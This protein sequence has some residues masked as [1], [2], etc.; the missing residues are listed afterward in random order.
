MELEKDIEIIE[1]PNDAKFKVVQLLFEGNPVMLCG[2]IHGFHSEILR[3]YLKDNQISPKTKAVHMAHSKR[4]V[5]AEI[6][7]NYIVMGMGI[8]EIDTEKKI[9][10]LP[11]GES[12]D[13]NRGPSHE[14]D[15]KLR[16]QF[17]G[18][19]FPEHRGDPKY[20]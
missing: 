12:A 3:K 10:T 18:W 16:L 6:G 7:E 11:Y 13:Y 15:E 2:D 19:N 20:F 9:L 4:R 8:S 14:F 17:S 5:P 1:L